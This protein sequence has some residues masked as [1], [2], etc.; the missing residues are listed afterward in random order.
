MK[1]LYG[2][3]MESVRKYYIFINFFHVKI[4]SFPEGCFLCKLISCLKSPK[5]S[6]REAAACCF[7][8]LPCLYSFTRGAKTASV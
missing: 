5:S 4:L 2:F 7:F 8:S 6:L 1:F 3:S